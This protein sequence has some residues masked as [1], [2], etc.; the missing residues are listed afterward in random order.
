MTWYDYCAGLDCVRIL[1]PL[2][3][4][5]WT[6]TRVTT[7]VTTCFCWMA[8]ISYHTALVSVH[9]V[10]FL[11]FFVL[12]SPILCCKWGFLVGEGGRGGEGGGGGA[13][14]RG[15]GK[16]PSLCEGS[17]TWT[18][19]RLRQGHTNVLIG[20]WVGYEMSPQNSCWWLCRQRSIETWLDQVCSDFTNPLIN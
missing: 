1:L 13:V 10:V 12:L 16:V 5:S 8:A 6:T 9:A 4:E 19:D 20:V 3:Q 11:Y 15:Q 18:N 14:C 7:Q 2:S 17:L